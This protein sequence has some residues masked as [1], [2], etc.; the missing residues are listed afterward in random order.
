[1]FWL[2][3]QGLA[4]RTEGGPHRGVIRTEAGGRGQRPVG[5]GGWGSVEGK[6]SVPVPA[7]N[8]RLPAGRT[9]WKARVTTKGCPLRT[10][11][12][13][14]SYWSVWWAWEFSF[15]FQSTFARFSAEEGKEKSRGWIQIQSGGGAWSLQPPPL[16]HTLPWLAAAPHPEEQPSGPLA[17]VTLHG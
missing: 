7:M 1:M 13:W 5:K 11:S 8:V 12:S 15:R 16:S 4:L 9:P 17:T 14:V 6:R 2:E 3:D 10:T